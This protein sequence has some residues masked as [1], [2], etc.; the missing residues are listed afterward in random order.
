MKKKIKMIFAALLTVTMLFFNVFVLAEGDVT[1]I[2]DTSSADATP[3]EEPTA[4]ETPA[5]T[6]APAATQTPAASEEPVETETPAAS[7]ES[8]A[9]ETPTASEESVATETPAASEE[10]VATKTPAVTQEPTAEPSGVDALVS[11]LS[12]SSSSFR[13]NLYASQDFNSTILHR[14]SAEDLV[15]VVK[16]VEDWVLVD[17]NGLRGYLPLSEPVAAETPAVTETPAPS[18]EPAATETPAVTEEPAITEEPAVT[19][20]PVPSEE[21]AV[22]EEPVVTEEPA[23]SASPEPTATPQSISIEII[24]AAQAEATPAPTEEPIASEEPVASEDPAVT[25]TPAP[26]EE[27]A[28]T[29][30]PAASEEPVASEEPLITEE[31]IVTEEPAATEAPVTGFVVPVGSLSIGSTQLNLYAQPDVNSEILY[32]FQPASEVAVLSESDNWVFVDFNGL[33]GYIAKANLV[34]NEPVD[35]SELSIR[36]WYV[37]EPEKVYYGDVLTIQGML[38]GF[39]NLPYEY[40]LQWQRASMSKDRSIGNNWV[41]V[42]GANS[43]SYSFTVNSETE[44][45]GWRLIARVAVPDELLQ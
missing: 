25:E 11:V 32:K 40:T 45:A 10:P 23:A 41:D 17:F 9:T 22:S 39:E 4:T 7:E 30:E 38:V 21:P 19:E 27:P 3:S 13:L 35:L 33:Q 12:L 5:V 2:P 42:E 37:N 14:F 43:L 34:T 31:P 20:T 1:P 6:E 44:W 18:E 8:V 36:I 15:V 16:R 29:D 26:S 28:V 24:P